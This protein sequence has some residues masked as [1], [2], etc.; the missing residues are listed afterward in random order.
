MAD[1]LD[2]FHSAATLPHSRP[3]VAIGTA[4]V[5]LQAGQTFTGMYGK[6]FANPNGAN[7]ISSSYVLALSTAVSIVVK[8]PIPTTAGLV[9]C[10]WFWFWY[11]W[12]EQQSIK[13]I[14]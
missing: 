3:E 2:I 1:P 8:S 9:I 12:Q 7:I 10:A 14:V 5:I 6:E 4:F 13:D 11:Y